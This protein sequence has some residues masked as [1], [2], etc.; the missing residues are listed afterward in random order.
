MMPGPHPPVSAA[1]SVLCVIKCFAA[2]IVVA[3]P[4]TMWTQSRS[5]ANNIGAALFTLTDAAV[6]CGGHGGLALFGTENKTTS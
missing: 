5:G 2:D 1:V 4:V 6:G 3:S